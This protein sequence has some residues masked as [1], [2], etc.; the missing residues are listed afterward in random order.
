MKFSDWLKAN[1]MS[2]DQAAVLLGTDP[3]YVWLLRTGR[4]GKQPSFDTI[5][6]IRDLTG[7][8]VTAR[9]LIA[10]YIPLEQWRQLQETRKKEKA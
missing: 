3:S 9:D 7:G 6:R 2:D 10:A 4:R 8:Q 5:M 1:A